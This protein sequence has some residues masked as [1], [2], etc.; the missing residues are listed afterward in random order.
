[1]QNCMRVAITGPNGLIGTYNLT[2][3]A[4]NG[5][6]KPTSDSDKT[7]TAGAFA[8]AIAA[9]STSLNEDTGLTGLSATGSDTAK[10]ITVYVYLDGQ[11]GDCFSDKV[12]TKNASEII[13]GVQVDLAL[14]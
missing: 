10:Y 12:G 6:L 13:S 7:P 1:M 11:D 5:V 14:A 9:T 8:P 4:P 3:T 2:G